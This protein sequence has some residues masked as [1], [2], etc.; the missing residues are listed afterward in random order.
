MSRTEHEDG[1]KKYKVV[2]FYVPK[3]NERYEQSVVDRVALYK[4]ESKY[5]NDFILSGKIDLED[6]SVNQSTENGY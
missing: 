3:P 6:D 4:L 2:K 5:R 1:T